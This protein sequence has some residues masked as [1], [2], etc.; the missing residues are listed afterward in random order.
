[1]TLAG[2]RSAVRVGDDGRVRPDGPRLRGVKA[3]RC[4]TDSLVALGDRGDRLLA[5]RRWSLAAVVA[6]GVLMAL[7]VSSGG[8]AGSR[9]ERSPSPAGAVVAPDDA[10][11]EL[12]LMSFNVCG[13][14]CRRGEVTRTAQFVARMAT[15]RGAGVVLLQELCYSQYREVRDLLARRG[16]SGRFAPQTHSMACANDDASHGTAFG[17]A[18]LVRGR[19]SRSV[20][21]HLPTT[22]GVE[23]RVLLGVTAWIAGRPTFVAGVH[24][25]PS[26]R[27]GLQQQLRT[28]EQFVAPR[29]AGAAIVGGDFNTLP[30][31]PALEPMFAR[32]TELDV[33]GP[34][35]PAMPTFAAKKID[36]VFLSDGHFT[37]ERATTVVTTM[38]DHRVYL[39]AAAVTPAVG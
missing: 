33:T 17:V 24:L 10:Y 3:G 36:Y 8:W 12:G 5:G 15:R 27:D 28:V 35:N 26:P 9:P 20:V 14:V 30:G 38:S 4:A 6:G 2:T 19:I 1:M 37:P 29:A 34:G 18:V 21:E 16:F 39:G 32:F 22:P 23:H 7:G 11:G 13:G 31:N 25:S